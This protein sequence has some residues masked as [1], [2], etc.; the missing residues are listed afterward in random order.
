MFPHDPYLAKGIEYLVALAFLLL[1]A[2]FWQYVNGEAA[3]AMPIRSQAAAGDHASWFQVP[4]LVFFHPGHAW[5]RA[6]APGVVTIGVDDFAQSLVGP[7]TGVALPAA[8]TALRTGERAWT[9]AADSK[10]VDMLA[11]VTG[12]VVEVNAKALDHAD[13]VNGDPFGSGWLMKV[14]VPDSKT[15]LQRL[16][17]VE[18]ARRWMTDVSDQLMGTMTPQLGHVLQDGGVPVHGIARAMDD[19][20]WDAIARRFLLS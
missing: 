13:L 3:A 15:A 1:F 7:L 18:A 5:A 17:T 16:V 12:T 11:P 10:A 8:G 14:R 6:D 9:L 19:A 2:G 20:H 4:D